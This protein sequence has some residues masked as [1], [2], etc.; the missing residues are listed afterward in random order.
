MVDGNRDNGREGAIAA[1]AAANGDA[2]IRAEGV[3]KTYDTGADR[4]QALRCVDFPVSRGELVA[5]MGP[6]G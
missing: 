3:V 1:P 6:S 5:V 4:V 2:I